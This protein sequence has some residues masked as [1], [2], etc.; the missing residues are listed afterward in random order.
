[1]PI[2]PFVAGVLSDLARG[3]RDLGI[4]FC[5]IGA[6][7]PELLLDEPAVRRTNDADATV[8][9]SSLGAFDAVKASLS[10]YGFTPTSRPYRLERRS[11]GW[12]DLLP[13]GDGIAPGDRLTLSKDCRSTWR[14]SGI[15]SAILVPI[16]DDLAVPVTPL[17]LYALLKLVAFSDRKAPKDIGS[18]LHCL[19][20][21]EAYSDRRYGL[22]HAGEPVP[23]DFGGAYLLGLGGRRFHD[24]S[25]VDTVR[26]VLTM[27]GDPD[28]PW[29]GTIA[30]EDDPFGS[31]HDRRTR[32][33]EL[34]T[35]FR[36]GA[37]I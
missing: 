30:R 6:L 16:A 17:P 12:I 9:V 23:F 32:V 26:P 31:D 11:G 34:L 10:D 14:A 2:D 28:S 13:Y 20:H 24:E 1:M 25:L 18:V 5:L 7:V 15:S 8:V 35:W 37:A 27:L 36:L 4:P 19:R 33:V 29:V 22:D 21:Y 3:L